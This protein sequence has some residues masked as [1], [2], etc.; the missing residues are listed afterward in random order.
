MLERY[1]LIKGIKTICMFLDKPIM[2][3]IGLERYDLI[4]G[5]KTFLC[6]LVRPKRA[7][8]ERYDLIKGIKTITLPTFKLFIF[9]FLV[10]TI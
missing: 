8:L 10:R 3:C 9:E 1:D 7:L 2:D 6:F 4:K 5:I